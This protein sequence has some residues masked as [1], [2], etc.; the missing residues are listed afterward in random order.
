MSGV[1]LMTDWSMQTV[2]GTARDPAC[3]KGSGVVQENHE[4]AQ[5]YVPPGMP[6]LNHDGRSTSYFEF[7]PMWVMYFPVVILW[8]LLAVRYRSLT[9]PL[10]ANPALAL[11]GM[12]GAQKSALFRQAGDYARQWILPWTLYTKDERAIVE[13]VVSAQTQ[14]SDAGLTYPVVGKPDVGCRGSGV[15]LL[16]D[17][18]AVRDYLRAFPTGGTIQFQQL[19]EWEAEA[20]VFYVRYPGQSRGTVTSLTLKY[21]PFVVGDGKSTLQQLVSE[22][23]RAG[24][25][26]HLYRERHAQRWESVIPEGEPYRLVFS[27]SHCRGAVFR[28]GARY[29]DVR[30][31]QALDKIFDDIPGFHYGRLDI[32]FRDLESLMRGEN[33]KIIEINGASS[34]SINIWDRNTSLGAALRTLLQQYRTLFKLGDANR[35]RGHKTPGVRALW[36]AWQYEQQLVKHYPQND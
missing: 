7:W 30:L 20:G 2:T 10:I 19:A 1:S 13:Q 6:E 17:S 36:R 27:A 31:E 28:D 32:K 12:V 9:L 25:L 18:D 35:S 11:S 16:S 8:L 34:E 3:D 23:A 33:F 29:I 14:L 4:Q 15:K 21:M 26:Q 22:D 5:G 24:A